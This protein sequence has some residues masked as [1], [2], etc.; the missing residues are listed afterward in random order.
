MSIPMNLEYGVNNTL[1]KSNLG[2]SISAMRVPTSPGWLIKFPPTV[3]RV[4]CGYSFWD[5]LR[6]ARWE[7]T[8]LWTTFSCPLIGLVIFPY[9]TMRYSITS[10]PTTPANPLFRLL[11][12]SRNSEETAAMILFLIARCQFSWVMNS[13]Q[14]CSQVS[15]IIFRAAYVAPV[16]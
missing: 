2:T 11:F 9:R 16:G 4:W 14:L 3:R 10:W 13:N 7:F 1:L 8:P 6:S 15:L 5:I 12:S